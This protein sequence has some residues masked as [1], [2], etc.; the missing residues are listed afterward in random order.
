MSAESSSGRGQASLSQENPQMSA[1]Q[2]PG[3]T[4]KAALLKPI[5]EVRRRFPSGH[6]CPSS[7]PSWWQNTWWLGKSF[8]PQPRGLTP[9]RGA[10]PSR[11]SS[12]KCRPHLPWE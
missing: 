3:K 5:L 2:K 12:R 8:I 4:Q 9:K 1:R 11:G 7:V 6:P 10:A